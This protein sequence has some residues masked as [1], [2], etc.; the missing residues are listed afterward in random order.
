[1]WLTLYFSIFKREKCKWNT[2]HAKCVKLHRVITSLKS[3]NFHHFS[4]YNFEVIKFW[5]L[6]C[7]TLRFIIG[8]NNKKKLLQNRWN[9]VIWWMSMK[10]SIVCIFVKIRCVFTKILN[11]DYFLTILTHSAQQQIDSYQQVVP[12]PPFV[13][14][15][16][17]APLA[18]H[19]NQSSH[20]SALPHHCLLLPFCQPTHQCQSPP[21]N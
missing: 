9:S 16:P 18:C 3:V 21:F 11:F 17:V 1:M 19:H 4:S 20:F 10:I 13:P 2:F 7:I 14:H 15:L 5:R 8:E 12:P 6:Y